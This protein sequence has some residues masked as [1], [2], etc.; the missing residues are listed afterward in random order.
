[1]SYLTEE[2][3]RAA[4]FNM[5]QFYKGLVEVYR[6]V[7]ID[8]TQDLGRRNMLMSSVQE[9]MFAQEI[10]KLYKG[11]RSD[12]RT[13]EADIMIESINTELECKLTTP[14]ANGGVSLQTDWSTLSQKGTLDY[15][16]VIADAT[17]DKFAVL[18]FIGLATDDFH[19]VAPGARGR[20]KMNKA[21]AMSKCRILM[22]DVI[23]MSEL[24]LRK[25]RRR[26][27]E[28][29]PSQ[30]TRLEQLYKSVDHWSAN[31]GRCKIVMDGV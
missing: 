23:D 8:I 7:G 17:F 21:K 20:A 19:P 26:I 11:V 13:G 27:T 31:P 4:V 10:A 15:L 6:K 22:G 30:K 9:H 24:N 2:M 5:Q 29:R 12:G 18:H 3:S 16:Y 25:A 14:R 28:C 1:M